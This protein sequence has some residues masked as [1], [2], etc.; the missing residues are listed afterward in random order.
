[1]H[2]PRGMEVE[3]KKTKE[4]Q[5]ELEYNFKFFISSVRHE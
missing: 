1:M 2:G 5:D 4:M 3:D